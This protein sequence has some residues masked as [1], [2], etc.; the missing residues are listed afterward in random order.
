M[1]KVA[2]AH[3]IPLLSDSERQEASMDWADTE[4]QAAF[5]AQVREVLE[6][7]LPDLY[8][9]RAK[10]EGDDDGGG[11]DAWGADRASS[12]P[13]RRKAA[14]QWGK[15][16]AERGWFAPQWPKEYGGGGLSSMEQFIYNQELA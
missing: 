8:K 10:G 5:R 4:E 9:R 12:D 2:S 14:E 6:H 11:F 16:L 3:T 1:A 15:V 13:E 7:G